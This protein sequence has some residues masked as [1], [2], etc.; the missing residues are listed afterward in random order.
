MQ[1]PVGVQLFFTYE[2][3]GLG[4]VYWTFNLQ[5]VFLPFLDLEN[6]LFSGWDGWDGMGLNGM[7]RIIKS[8][9]QISLYE[10]IEHV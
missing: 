1:T 7:R 3:F 6:V 8:V 10:Y 2:L 4:M 9:L 5:A